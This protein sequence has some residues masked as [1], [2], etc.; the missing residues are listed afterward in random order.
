M[1]RIVENFPVF[2][3]VWLVGSLLAVIAV[4]FVANFV[5]PA[6]RLKGEL[7][8]ALLALSTIKERG[9]GNLVEISEITDGSM[10]TPE[11]AHSW[12]EYTETLHPQYEVDGSGQNRIVRWR[13]TAL[14]ETFFSGQA[15]VDTPLKA[16]FYKHLPGI[17][18]GLG[19]IGTFLGLIMGLS[20]FDVS[21]PAKAQSELKSLINAVGH[22]FYVSGAAI[23]MAMFFTWIE[24]SLVTARHRQVVNQRAKVS[25]CQRPKLSSLLT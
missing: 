9:D 20:S 24:K 23:A 16:D 19:I 13:A 5:L 2:W 15:I 10:G 18:T 1:D 11:L 17:L 12:S 7:A 8:N 21:D 3:H 14:A 6:W 22:A 4:G 25:T